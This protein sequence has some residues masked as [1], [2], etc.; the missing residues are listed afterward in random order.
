[1]IFAVWS[2][3]PT[4]GSIPGWGGDPLFN[5][6]TFEVAWHNLGTTAGLW[7]AP[8][9]G[10][11]ALGLAFSENQLIPALLFW[12]IRAVSGNGASALGPRPIQM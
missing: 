12:P 4:A 10:G 5:L 9:F 3:W 6:W 7:E 1:V 8:L 2:Y 11:S